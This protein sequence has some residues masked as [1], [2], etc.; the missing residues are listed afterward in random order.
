MNSR[1]FVAAVSTALLLATNAARAHD[2]EDQLG[3]VTFA[4]SCNAKAHALFET[5]LAKLHSYW[6]GEARKTFD[7]ALKEDPNCAM[8]GLGM[9]RSGDVV[10]AKAEIATM[11]GLREKLEKSNN[12]YWADRTEEQMLAVSAWVALAEGNKEQAEKFMRTA[13]DNEDGSVKHVAMENRLYPLRELYAE[14]LLEM[15]QAAPVLREFEA[16]LKGYPNRYRSIYGIARAAEASGDRRKAADH[17]NRLMALA[18]NADSSRPELAR[19]R[20][21]VAQR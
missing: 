9:A 10:G 14:L 5:G 1:H 17:Y 21:Y 16:A 6:F 12:A 7:A 18:K 4:T 20:D 2:G 11:Q 13:A 15:G 19:A 3:K 8:A